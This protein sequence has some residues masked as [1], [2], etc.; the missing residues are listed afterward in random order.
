MGHISLVTLGVQDV[1]R[2]TAFYEQLGWRKS[3]ASVAGEVSFLAGGT[4]V[5]ALWGRDALVDDSRTQAAAAYAMNVESPAAVDEALE[6]AASAGARVTVAGRRTE[7][8]GYNGYFTDPDG[9]LWEVAH[10]PDF[11]LGDDGQ[12]FLPGFEEDIQQQIAETDAKLTDFITNADG[13]GGTT[14]AQLA[15]AV[16]ATLRQSYDAIN[17]LLAEH[18][19]NVVL[20]T[21]LSLSQRSRSIATA[22]PDYWLT[23]A[24]STIVSSMIRPGESPPE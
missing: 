3:S 11:P 1:A 13:A 5:L 20:G 2:A 24:A 9:H 7:W 21:M 10:N 14:V 23:S 15:D 22:E 8:G 18:P 6:A 19:N 17:T 16:V 12:L 4:V